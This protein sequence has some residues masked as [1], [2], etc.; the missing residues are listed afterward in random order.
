LENS[1][2]DI[3]KLLKMIQEDI[4]E[5]EKETIKDFLWK[6]FGQEV[7]RGSVVGFP[8]YYKMKLSERQEV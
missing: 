1:P 2:R 4:V 6:E 8:E 5:E 3:G 7:I